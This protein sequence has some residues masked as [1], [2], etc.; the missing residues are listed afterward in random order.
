[1]DNHF[2]LPDSFRKVLPPQDRNQTTVRPV[3]DFASYTLSDEAPCTDN[4]NESHHQTSTL[5]RVLAGMVV[6]I[7]LLHVRRVFWVET[8]QVFV[9]NGTLTVVPSLRKH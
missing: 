6:R 1:M 7:L 9:N 5:S 8:N 4:R 2:T 3:R